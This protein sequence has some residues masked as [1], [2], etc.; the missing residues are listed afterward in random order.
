MDY[1]TNDKRREYT[2]ADHA[3]LKYDI[4]AEDKS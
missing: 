4:S 3:G 1:R 2:R